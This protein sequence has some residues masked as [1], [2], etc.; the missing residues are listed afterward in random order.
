LV[1]LRKRIEIAGDDRE[2]RAQL[3]RRVRDEILAHRLEPL[4][5]ADVADDQQLAHAGVG[6]HDMKRQPAASSM[7]DI[8]HDDPLFGFAWLEVLEEVRVAN[9]VLDPNAEIALAP[10]PEPLGRTAVEP[11]DLILGTEEDGAF[12]HRG[13][14]AAKLP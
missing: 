1:V 3:M 4:L 11:Q 10:Q 8:V 7:P 5:A 9:E 2:R 13:R 14:E 12:R 6:A